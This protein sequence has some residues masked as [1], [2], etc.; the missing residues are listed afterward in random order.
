MT[1]SQA[2]EALIARGMSEK[3]IAVAAHSSQPV[4]NRIKRGEIKRTNYELGVRLVGLAS[5][6]PLSDKPNQS[7]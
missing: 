5:A 7:N 4:I 1:P 3:S 6:E 2:I